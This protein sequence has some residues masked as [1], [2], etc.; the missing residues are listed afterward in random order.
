MNK[1]KKSN[2]EKPKDQVNF[3]Y[4]LKDKD[5]N[6]LVQRQREMKWKMRLMK[7]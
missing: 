2:K 5:L 6:K 4:Y 3:F 1:S 7:S